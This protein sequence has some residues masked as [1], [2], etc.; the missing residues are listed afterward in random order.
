VI[1]SNY[2]EGTTVKHF[3]LQATTSSFG[4]VAQCAFLGRIAQFLWSCTRRNARIA[5]IVAHWWC[6]GQL[7]PASTGF[8]S[9]HVAGDESSGMGRLQHFLKWAH[10]EASRFSAVFVRSHTY[11]SMAYIAAYFK[12]YQRAAQDY[13]FVWT[14]VCAVHHS[15]SPD[16]MLTFL[17]LVYTCNRSRSDYPW[18][19]YWLWCALRSVLRYLA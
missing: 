8:Q 9:M 4:S 19:Y 5:H 13:L 11:Y 10:V 2:I 15:W 18:W 6:G 7:H 14:I 3:L 1:N 16:L 12:S 17:C